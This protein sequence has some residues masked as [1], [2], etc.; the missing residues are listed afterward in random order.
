M[1]SAFCRMYVTSLQILTV[2]HDTTLDIQ[3][4][5]TE[6]ES[7]GSQY[8]KFTAKVSNRPMN[9]PKKDYKIQDRNKV[10]EIEN[11]HILVDIRVHTVLSFR[12]HWD[13]CTS[14]W[15][16]QN[17]AWGTKKRKRLP[18][19]PRLR[20]QGCSSKEAKSQQAWDRTFLGP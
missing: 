16:D 11:G 7:G 19:F 2:Q 20:Y 4:A 6:G 13:S 9:Q 17:Q 12:G 10:K 1:L 3:T 18:S 14:W 15:K 8:G 5:N